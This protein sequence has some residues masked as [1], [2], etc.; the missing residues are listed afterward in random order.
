MSLPPNGNRQGV[1]V[2]QRRKPWPYSPFPFIPFSRDV[3]RWFSVDQSLA[4]VFRRVPFL[5]ASQN[6]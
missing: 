3:E 4:R 1:R 2:F 5:S 6:L